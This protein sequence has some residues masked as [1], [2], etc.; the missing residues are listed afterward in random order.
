VSGDSLSGGWGSLSSGGGSSSFG[1]LDSKALLLQTM[2]F[3]KSKP[4]FLLLAERA[5]TYTLG[6]SDEF[7][8][9]SMLLQ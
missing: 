6:E 9:T 8:K 1:S 2:F 5:C 4:L 7:C 3:F